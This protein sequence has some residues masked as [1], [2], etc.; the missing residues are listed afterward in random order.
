MAE[1]LDAAVE[2]VGGQR[3]EGQDADGARRSR[4]AIAERRARG[5]AG[6]HG[7]RQ[8]AGLPGAR[9]STTPWPRAP[10]SSSPRPRSRCSAS[11]STATCPGWRPR[12]RRC[13]A[14]RPTFAIL[15]GRR[16]YL[17]LHKLHGGARRR[18]GRRAVRPVRGLRAGPAGQAAARVGRR[19]PRPATATS[20]CPACRTPTWRQVSVTARECLGVARVPG[21]VTTASPSGP[22]PRPAAPTSWSPTT[23]CWPSTRWTTARCCPSTTSWS[24]TRRTS[25]WTG[26]PGWPPPS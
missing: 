14:A 2:A 11:S 4:A 5:R 13:S 8:V 22:A 7:H 10:P 26:S 3:R 18:P 17:C 19:T 16:N 9:R 15:K 20:W 6:R 23:R 25:W 21:R 1:L 24:S 12:W